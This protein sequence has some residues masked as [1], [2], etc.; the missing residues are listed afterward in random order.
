MAVKGEGSPRE[1]VGAAVLDRRQLAMHL[2]RG[3]D[4]IAAELL[5]DG[6][7][8]EADAEDGFA[9]PAKVFMMSRLTPAS[10]GVQ[11]PGEMRIRAPD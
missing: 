6:L 4:D 9:L 1:N 8:A 3:A 11:G 7:V 5:A 2:A 10:L